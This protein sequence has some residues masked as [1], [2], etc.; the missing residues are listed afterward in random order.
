MLRMI[1]LNLAAADYPSFN[2]QKGPTGMPLLK[3]QNMKVSVCRSL[4]NPI[5]GPLPPK[6]EA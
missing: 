6:E 3:R 1:A 2:M 4:S 5:P